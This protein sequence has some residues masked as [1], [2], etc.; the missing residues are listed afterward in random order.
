MDDDRA[1]REGMNSAEALRSIRYDWLHYIQ[2]TVQAEFDNRLQTPLHFTHKAVH[3]SVREVLGRFRIRA[4]GLQNGFLVK[5]DDDEVFFLY[6][7]R[8][9]TSRAVEEGH[10]VL[11]FR[12]LNDDEL[13]FLD[14][15]DRKMLVSMS[16]KRVVDFHGHLCPELAIGMKACEYASKLLI[17]NEDEP[18]GRLS[19]IAENNTSALDAFQILLGVTVGNQALRVLDFGKHNYTFSTN[20]S[21]K[22]FM[23]RLRTLD[24][25]DEAS[26]QTFEHKIVE[27][28]I[29]LDEVVEFQ[30]LLDARV[31]RLLSSLPEELFDLD[32]ECG[33]A[34]TFEAPTSYVLCSKCGQQVRRDRA[35]KVQSGFCCD[36]C[37]KA[38]E[39][40]HLTRSLH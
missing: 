3:R 19:V 28:Q 29:T 36:P 24:Y 12:V 5:T 30:K 4:D 40:R 26:Y 8:P 37:I 32:T 15:E 11:S 7:H 13:M 9:D 18:V 17:E 39:N 25:G 6:F 23:L 21:E 22:N 34:L 14:R 20:N 31:D 35:V 1:R 16:V 38:V 33:E 10:W 2:A 27:N